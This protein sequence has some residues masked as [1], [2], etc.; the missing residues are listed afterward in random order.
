MI[1]SLYSGQ[2]FIKWNTD[3]KVTKEFKLMENY[4]DGMHFTKMPFLPYGVVSL[5]FILSKF[6]N[7]NSLRRTNFYVKEAN[8]DLLYQYGAEFI[9]RQNS[10]IKIPVVKTELT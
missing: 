4:V 1:Q 5:N 3:K 9:I 10:I 8:I 7:N 6:S 2:P